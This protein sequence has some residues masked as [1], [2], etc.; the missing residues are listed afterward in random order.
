MIPEAPRAIAALRAAR[1]PELWLQMTDTPG[2]RAIPASSARH[3]TATT[4]TCPDIRTPLPAASYPKGCRHG[5]RRSW[6]KTKQQP[7]ILEILGDDFGIGAW[8]GKVHAA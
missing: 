6:R 8:C 3:V 7:G 5:Q 2:P 4:P 1:N